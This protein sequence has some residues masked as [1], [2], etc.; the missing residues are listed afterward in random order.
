MDHDGDDEDDKEEGIVEEILE[1]VEFSFLE[2]PSVDLV[3][4]LHQDKSVEEDAV[5][6]ASLVVPLTDTD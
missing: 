4:D 3:E 2:F 1:D 5:V 6:F